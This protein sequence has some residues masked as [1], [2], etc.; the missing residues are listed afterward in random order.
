MAFDKCVDTRM[1]WTRGFVPDYRESLVIEVIGAAQLAFDNFSA[2]AGGV[3]QTDGVSHG[4]YPG[5]PN[6]NGSAQR[7]LAFLVL[8]ASLGGRIIWTVALPSMP[9]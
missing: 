3:S 4:L 1:Q 8:V 9:E 7:V 6:L 2:A 5:A